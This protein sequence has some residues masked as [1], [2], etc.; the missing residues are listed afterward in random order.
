[1]VKIGKNQK[2]FKNLHKTRK[3]LDKQLEKAKSS[4]DKNGKS[5]VIG[6]FSH[7]FCF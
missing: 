5:L 6:L 7:F 2:R 3:S 1:M 4:S